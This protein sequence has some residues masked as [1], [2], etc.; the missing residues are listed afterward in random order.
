MSLWWVLLWK[1][2]ILTKSENRQPAAVQSVSEEFS[3]VE[4]GGCCH[5]LNAYSRLLHNRLDPASIVSVQSWQCSDTPPQSSLCAVKTETLFVCVCV[6][7]N[8][9]LRKTQLNQKSWTSWASCN[10]LGGGRLRFYP[11]NKIISASSL[12]T[13][14]QLHNKLP[15]A[16][17]IVTFGL[18]PTTQSGSLCAS[19]VLRVITQP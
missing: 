17:C 5:S 8:Q 15:S 14:K 2:E 3:L 9:K 19:C 18:F 7:A 10:F 6:D 1:A 13:G 11:M 4:K 16:V 12:K